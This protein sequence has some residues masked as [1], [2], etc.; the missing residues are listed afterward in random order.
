MHIDD[1][2]SDVIPATLSQRLIN[3]ISK[4]VLTERHAQ[5]TLDLLKREVFVEPVCADEKSVTCFDLCN[6]SVKMQILMNA[7]CPGE[8]IG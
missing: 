5:H 1:D 8:H 4:H 2:P 3:Q 6:I 7:D